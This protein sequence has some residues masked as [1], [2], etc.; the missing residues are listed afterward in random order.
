M[1]TH[2]RGKRISSSVVDYT[3][4]FGDI[5][6]MTTMKSCLEGAVPKKV[7]FADDGHGDDDDTAENN[8]AMNM[9]MF[10]TSEEDNQCILSTVERNRRI[11][12]MAA[13]IYSVNSVSK[14]PPSSDDGARDDAEEVINVLGPTLFGA[15][16]AEKKS[17]DNPF[18]T[19]EQFIPVILDNFYINQGMTVSRGGV[20]HNIKL[21]SVTDPAYVPAD[22][23]YYIDLIKTQEKI[24]YALFK[25]AASA[26]YPGT[27]EISEGL[28]SVTWNILNDATRGK[29]TLENHRKQMTSNILVFS[30][31]VDFT[32]LVRCCLENVQRK[33][34]ANQY[35]QQRVKDASNGCPNVYVATKV[36]VTLKR[37]PPEKVARTIDPKLV[38][39]NTTF[40]PMFF[41]D[42]MDRATMTTDE[43]A[44]V[45][46]AENKASTVVTRMFDFFMDA[47]RLLLEMVNAP[48]EHVLDR[49]LKRNY[50]LA[51]KFDGLGY[52]FNSLV[53]ESDLLDNVS[54][55]VARKVHYMRMYSLYYAGTSYITA[56]HMAT[57]LR[58]FSVV[59]E[60]IMQLYSGNFSL[61][62]RFFIEQ[63]YFSMLYVPCYPMARESAA[64]LTSL[65]KADPDNAEHWGVFFAQV[66]T[67]L[68]AV[69]LRFEAM[70]EAEQTH[71]ES[72]MR[73]DKFLE[74]L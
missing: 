71:V 48:P 5:F 31:D 57:G 34:E 52:M 40:R 50:N 6:Y 47:Y 24:C 39:A 60:L 2:T 17:M 42:V 21:P 38:V 45:K 23:S 14:N 73:T 54:V 8:D 59:Q 28:N 16:E 10:E 56:G 64:A 63:L 55:A 27:I 26:T 36:H 9:D 61:L 3:S 33:I 18:M 30:G 53:M 41:F 13:E 46:L 35:V 65:V 1:T 51:R 62:T 43:K 72:F 44:S 11:A 70:E 66:N 32:G 22:R 74:N 19:F 15:F 29:C 49:H 67:V 7:K 68:D 4:S 20:K 12:D 37:Q 69:R 58:Y 25:T